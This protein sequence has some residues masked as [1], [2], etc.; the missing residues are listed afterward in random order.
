[1]LRAAPGEPDHRCGVG[2]VD[3]ASKPKGGSRRA[4]AGEQPGLQKLART[5]DSGHATSLLCARRAADAAQERV[6]VEQQ[7][8]T[9]QRLE[10]DEGVGAS[11]HREGSY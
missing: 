11:A 10:K 2:P 8:G 5:E 4:G 6:G 7:P 1:M 3:R 9:G